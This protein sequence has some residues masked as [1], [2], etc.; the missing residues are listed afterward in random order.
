M[1]IIWSSAESVAGPGDCDSAGRGTVRGPQHRL[2]SQ[3]SGIRSG[4]QTALPQ[5]DVGV[6]EVARV[7]APERLTGGLHDD[8][9]GGRR[10]SHDGFD[11]PGRGDGVAERELGG[12]WNRS[13]GAPCRGPGS[14]GARSPASAPAG[15]RRTATAPCSRI[16]A[17]D[18]GGHEGRARRGRS[19][20]TG[21]RS[22]TQRV[23]TLIRGLHEWLGGRRRAS[24]SRGSSGP[25]RGGRRPGG[26]PPTNRPPI[27]RGRPPSAEGPGSYQTSSY[28][29]RDDG[30]NPRLGPVDGI[31][32]LTGYRRGAS[33]P[34]SVMVGSMPTGRPGSPSLS[35]PSSLCGGGVANGSKSHRE[36][37]GDHRHGRDGVRAR[38]RL[39]SRGPRSPCG[40]D[41][42]GGAGP[43]VDLGG[44]ALGLAVADGLRPRRRPWYLVVSS[45]PTSRPVAPHLFKGTPATWGRPQAPGVPPAATHRPPWLHE[46]SPVVRGRRRLLRAW[47][48]C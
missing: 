34:P 12:A 43:V 17:D 48:A 25:S 32:G 6:P 44:R 13:E 14:C 45:A 9:T 28:P 18:A 5:V 36:I 11:F 30:A 40:T 1:V 46:H 2:P 39:E 22:S 19:G 4:F 42:R 38:R 16:L 37:S 21:S 27:A 15:G 23:R 47:S 8:R 20:G 3:S 31:E 35:V 10:L 24:G 7:A 29:G 33:H 41:R 26:E